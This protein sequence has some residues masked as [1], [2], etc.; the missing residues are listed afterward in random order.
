MMG[1]QSIQKSMS[2]RRAS[3]TARSSRRTSFCNSPSAYVQAKR[4]AIEFQILAL[5]AEV[6]VLDDL[7]S[8][9]NDSPLLLKSL[10]QM[11]DE[12]VT[13]KVDA[14]VIS[15]G[16]ESVTGDSA[17]QESMESAVEAIEELGRAP[18]MLDQSQFSELCEKLTKIIGCST[19][20]LANI[21]VMAVLFEEQSS[22]SA[23]M[24][25]MEKMES[26]NKKQEFQKAAHDERMMDLYR[27]FDFTR[28][29]KV[30]FKEVVFG[31]YKLT[32]D[33]DGASK[34]AVDAL[35]VMEKEDLR[36]LTFEQFAKLIMNVVAAHPNHVK[37]EDIADKLTR[38]ASNHDSVLDMDS[39]Q[40]LFAMD[41][42]LERAVQDFSKEDSKESVEEA[43]SKLSS[44][45][46]LKAARLF[47]MW[48]LDSNGFVTFHELALGLRKFQETTNL[49]DCVSETIKIME[50]FDADSD[51]Q[52]N[53]QEFSAFLAKFAS[54][55]GSAFLD[56]VDF[57]IVTTALKENNDKEK[58]YI[59][60]LSAGD[61][62]YWGC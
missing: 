25:S 35:L 61:I 50:N 60:S 42:T 28:D 56:M 31:L 11:L 55:Q 30:S 40:H 34:A 1:D 59:E 27:L 7:N 16:L 8:M 26:A 44:V 3:L 2:V 20:E 12:E 47:D 29:G 37:F 24:M 23:A 48:D 14:G 32:E 49:Q 5:Q 39:I 46:R 22:L 52:L 10:F 18:V 21:I 53:R 54:T 36:S 15:L 58:A 6:K 51:Q 9:D 19:L 43:I 4:S 45:E 62:Y 57:M 41:R 13:G 33:I 17:F 38:L